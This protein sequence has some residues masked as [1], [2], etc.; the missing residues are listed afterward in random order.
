MNIRNI[1]LSSA[2]VITLLAAFP[3]Q[4]QDYRA[5]AVAMMKRD[6]HAKGI[7]SADA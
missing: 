7:A 2:A 6:F 3:I 5:Q 4:A 1:S